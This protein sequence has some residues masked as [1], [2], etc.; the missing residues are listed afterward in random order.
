MPCTKE[1][2]M[3]KWEDSGH[4]CEWQSYQQ[5]LKKFKD[6]SLKGDIKRMAEIKTEIHNL[7]SLCGAVPIPEMMKILEDVE[8]SEDN[9]SYLRSS[10]NLIERC[11][12]QRDVK[13]IDALVTDVNRVTGCGCQKGTRSKSGFRAQLDAAL[14]TDSTDALEPEPEMHENSGFLRQL[15]ASTKGSRKE[16]KRVKPIFRYASFED[17]LPEI[18]TNDCAIKRHCSSFPANEGNVCVKKSEQFANRSFIKEENQ[19]EF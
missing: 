12:D 8:I 17:T 15:D 4:I 13:T 9:A 7:C 5:L 6:A 16:S 18:C 14:G 11:V 2:I 19:N 3:Q 1:E 10:L